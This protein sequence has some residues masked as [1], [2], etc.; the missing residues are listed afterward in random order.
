MT[1]LG[2][3]MCVLDMRCRSGPQGQRIDYMLEKMLLATATSLFYSNQL[4]RRCS[5]NK[6]RIIQ[7]R[8]SFSY[9]LS[10]TFWLLRNGNFSLF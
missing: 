6:G 9:G 3:F 1:N 10:K 5:K 8:Q 7:C 4:F 2:L